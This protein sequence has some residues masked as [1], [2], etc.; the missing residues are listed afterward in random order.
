MLVETNV[1][2]LRLFALKKAV[3]WPKAYFFVGRRNAAVVDWAA[4]ESL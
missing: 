2:V 1:V 4:F 3:V